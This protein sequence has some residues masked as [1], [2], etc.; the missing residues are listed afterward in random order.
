MKIKD[1]K[2]YTWER[3]MALYQLQKSTNAYVWDGEKYQEKLVLN[4][5]MLGLEN[6]FCRRQTIILSFDM[7]YDFERDMFDHKGIKYLTDVLTANPHVILFGFGV[8]H[9]VREIHLL[10]DSD[11][12]FVIKDLLNLPRYENNNKYCNKD[13]YLILKLLL[14]KKTQDYDL[15]NIESG[16]DHKKRKLLNNK[17]K[18]DLVLK[19]KKLYNKY[20]GWQFEFRL[21]LLLPY[22][23]HFIED[24]IDLFHEDRLTDIFKIDEELYVWTNNKETTKEA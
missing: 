16:Y 7:K 6:C 21:H 9:S 12:V 23:Y 10:L 1:T 8:T 17:E 24:P 18:E 15:Y 13:A 19:I 2:S 4:D 3:Y 20:D 11:S 22:G 5:L 14:G